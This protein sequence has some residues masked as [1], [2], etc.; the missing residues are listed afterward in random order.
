MVVIIHLAEKE[1]EASRKATMAKQD[2]QI[3]S[4]ICN[5]EHL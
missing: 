3:N 4:F 2:S 5:K 1:K